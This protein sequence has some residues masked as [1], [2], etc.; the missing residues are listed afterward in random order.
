M[1]FH[2]ISQIRFQQNLNVQVCFDLSFRFKTRQSSNLPEKTPPLNADMTAM[3]DKVTAYP[4][5]GVLQ[6][7]MTVLFFEPK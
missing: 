2:V 7:R 6:G 1:S 3:Q 5:R 4:T